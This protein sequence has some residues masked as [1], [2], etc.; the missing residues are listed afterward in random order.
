M[1]NADIDNN[2]D[3]IN[4]NMFLEHNK[5]KVPKKIS[6]NHMPKKMK[7]RAERELILNK[8]KKILGIE[9][10]ADILKFYLYDIESD[11]DKISQIMSLKDDIGKYF[12]SKNNAIY[13]N[14][15]KVKKPHTALI[16]LV[17]KEEGYEIFTSSRS[18]RVNNTIKSSI[19]Y[20]MISPTLTQTT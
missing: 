20:V 1:S 11:P 10:N 12:T 8:M 3:N 9:E 7:F 16:R 15:E 4:Y 2:N 19:L 18:V 5:K 17:F 13:R 14:E 6:S